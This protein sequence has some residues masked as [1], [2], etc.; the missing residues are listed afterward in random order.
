M[1]G[2]YLAGETSWYNWTGSRYN[3]K[4]ALRADVINKNYSN[5]TCTVRFYGYL[6]TANGSSWTSSYS[7]YL[8]IN[9]S[10]VMWNHD[11]PGYSP[12][13]SMKEVH[14]G[15]WDVNNV[16]I[17]DDGS[18]QDIYVY[19]RT[20]GPYWDG[21]IHR[22]FG[23]WFSAGI[24]MDPKVYSIW[25]SYGNDFQ[26]DGAGLPDTQ[27]KT[28]GKTSTLT[29]SVPWSPNYTFVNW[30]GSD[31]KTYSPN[32][33]LTH[34]YDLILTAQWQPNLY[35]IKYNYDNKGVTS[36]LTKRVLFGDF[37][38]LESVPSKVGYTFKNWLLSSNNKLYQAGSTIRIDDSLNLN[39]DRNNIVFTAQWEANKYNITLHKGLPG[40]V[41]YQIA[42]L[43]QTYDSPITGN[44][45]Y[46][47]LGYEI[48]GWSLEQHEPFPPKTDYSNWLYISAKDYT[49]E[50]CYKTYTI[51]ENITLYPLFE[52]KST[53]YVYKD[54]KWNLVLPFVYKDNKWQLALGYVYNNNQW[55]L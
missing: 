53:M 47:M 49:K 17:N 34:N 15:T 8:K 11:W 36:E 35:V 46:E 2:A 12:W 20:A 39:S 26:V 54:N 42:V 50:V 10:W 16:K 51:P 13:K 55:K 33:K 1:Y 52:Y 29:S 48:V 45:T 18:V 43:R 27:S 19:G 31:G 4:L 38:T 25:F 5:R 40:D 22:E 6:Y 28:Y 37:F 3:T 7:I 14:L 21:R 41:N 44:F 24:A 32:Q 30:L 23:G 9:D